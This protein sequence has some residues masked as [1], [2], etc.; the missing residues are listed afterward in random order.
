MARKRIKYYSAKRRAI[1][2]KGDKIDALTLFEMH[3]WVCCL[4]QKK[5]NKYLRVPN[6][7]AATIEHL[8]PISRGGAHSWDNCRPA[9]LIC[10]LRKDNQY[11]DDGI[12]IA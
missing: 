4:C 6:W 11:P 10:N 1:Y 5:I 9:H 8:I 12:M 7:Y 3:G 2:A